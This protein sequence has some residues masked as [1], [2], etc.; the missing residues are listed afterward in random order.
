[1]SSGV[2]TYTTT[3]LPAG[4]DSI[5]A[6]YGGSSTDASSTSTALSQVVNP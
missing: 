6:G 5:T 1:L 4:T 3:T 2:A